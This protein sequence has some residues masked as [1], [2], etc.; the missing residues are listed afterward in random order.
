MYTRRNTEANAYVNSDCKY[1]KLL[2]IQYYLLPLV[3]CVGVAILLWIKIIKIKIITRK[4]DLFYKSLF[5]G[6]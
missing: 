6:W 5:I 3:V 4:L 1:C 2:T